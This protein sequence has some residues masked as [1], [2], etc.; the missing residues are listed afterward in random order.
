MDVGACV[1][2]SKVYVPEAPKSPV[3]LFH[4]TTSSLSVTLSLYALP[5]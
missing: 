3:Y 2:T 1:S 5:L 4:E